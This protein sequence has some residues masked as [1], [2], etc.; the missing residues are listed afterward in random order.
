MA[1]TFNDIK[2]IQFNSSVGNTI[3]LVNKISGTFEYLVFV[4]YTAGRACGRQHFA[5]A[6]VYYIFTHFVCVIFNTFLGCF[7]PLCP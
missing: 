7:D 4:I 6:V 2:H 3:K 1:N 5:A